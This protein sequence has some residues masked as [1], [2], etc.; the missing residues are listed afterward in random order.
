MF[1]HTLKPNTRLPP[2]SFVN[3]SVLMKV[4]HTKLYIYT[5]LPIF[6]SKQ[7]QSNR[8]IFSFL[9]F[10]KITNTKMIKC[11]TKQ[12]FQIQIQI[13]ISKHM[14]CSYHDE[15][16]ETCHYNVVLTILACFYFQRVGLG[17]WSLMQ[18][19]N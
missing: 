1:V 6:R 8:D 17:L 15:K 16:Y 10:L 3:I 14:F 19:R 2:T 7:Q 18:S 11:S 12:K 4:V 9:I 5:F 13:S